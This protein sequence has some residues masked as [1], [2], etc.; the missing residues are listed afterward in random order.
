MNLNEEIKKIQKEWWI[1]LSDL[2]KL[3]LATKYHLVDYFN[4]IENFENSGFIGVIFDKEVIDP[5]YKVLCLHKGVFDIYLVIKKNKKYIL[6][7]RSKSHIPKYNNLVI[8]YA[9][10]KRIPDNELSQLFLNKKSELFF[11]EKFKIK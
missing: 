1:N 10:N 4:K 3:C 2:D 7:S 8:N 5:K 11:R 9:N 6:N